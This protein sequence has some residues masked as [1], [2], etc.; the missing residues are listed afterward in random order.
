MGRL[1][2]NP[3]AFVLATA[4]GVPGYVRLSAHGMKRCRGGERSMKPGRLQAYRPTS[5]R[6]SLGI[7]KPRSRIESLGMSGSLL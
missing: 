4:R 5:V 1:V 3:A 6:K 7:G 2:G